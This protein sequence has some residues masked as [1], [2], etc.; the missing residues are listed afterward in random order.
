MSFVCWLL[1]ESTHKWTKSFPHCVTTPHYSF[2]KRTSSWLQRWHCSKPF[3]QC[4]NTENFASLS[5]LTLCFIRSRVAMTSRR[6]A[7]SKN[8]PDGIIMSKFLWS[9]RVFPQALR[10]SAGQVILTRQLGGV[11]PLVFL[12][13]LLCSTFVRRGVYLR[14]KIP[15]TE[16]LPNIT[17][18]PS[19]SFQ[20]KVDD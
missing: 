5:K 19:L 7:S 17:A 10:W 9:L 14:E 13:V 1:A 20:I 2:H 12:W 11:P 15:G 4:S 16:D 3:W 18:Q 8:N 6:R